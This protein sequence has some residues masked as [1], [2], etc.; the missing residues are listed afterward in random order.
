MPS[1]P[2]MRMR[3]SVVARSECSSILRKGKVVRYVCSKVASQEAQVTMCCK[4]VIRCTIKS[5]RHPVSLD[6]EA[7]M[8]TALSFRK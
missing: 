2:D 8:T 1:I 5:H 3:E 6:R 7:R 4:E